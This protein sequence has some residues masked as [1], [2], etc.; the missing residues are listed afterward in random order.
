MLTL[1]QVLSTWEDVLA[2]LGRV[3]VSW[4]G[5]PLSDR[6][7]DTYTEAIVLCSLHLIDLSTRFGG[8]GS[9]REIVAWAKNLVTLD[10]YDVGAALSEV[11]VML[12][13]V[14]AP[15]TYKEFKRP[16]C[17]E[18]PFMGML[19]APIR[20]ALSAFLRAPNYRG[21]YVVYQSLS[22]LT[23]L[24]LLD[25]PI[26]LEDEYVE[27]ENSLRSGPY[28]GRMIAEM[29]AIM[30]E[31][32]K[33]FSIS[34]ENFHPVHGPGATAELS[35][36]ANPLSKYV[37]AS[38]HDPL[39][40]Y[41]FRHYAGVDV[42]SYLPFDVSAR[43]MSRQAKVVMVPKSIK[44]R[45]TISKESTLLQYLEQAIARAGVDYVHAHPELS[46]HIDL[47]DQAANA[48]LAID[49]SGDGR[50]STIDLSSAS[51][52]VTYTNVKA[53]FR[54]TPLYPYLVALRSR[55]AELP[56]GRVVELEKYAPMGSALCFLVE[57]LIFACAVEYTVRR[58]RRT[59]L[60][61][62]PRWRVY[63]DDIIVQEPL[64]E[65]TLL[66]LGGLG[67]RVNESKSFTYPGR[68]RESCGGE[69]Y[70]GYD[71]TPLKISRRFASVRGGFTSSHAAQFIGTVEM[72]NSCHRYGFQYTRAWLV[73]SC[74]NNRIAPPLFSETGR[75]SIYSP[76]P[77]NYRAKRRFSRTHVLEVEVCI[78]GL[79][80]RPKVRRFLL[81]EE[82]SVDP[83]LER[84]RYFEALRRL[85]L[86]KVDG[87]LL[88]EDVIEVPCSPVPLRLQKKWKNPVAP[89]Q[90]HSRNL[91]QSNH[92]GDV[93]HLLVGDIE[94]WSNQ[95][96]ELGLW[97]DSSLEQ[98]GFDPDSRPVSQAFYEG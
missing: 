6:D 94:D 8:I 55:T 98:V 76:R 13:H 71:V 85:S 17:R 95:G 14:H 83:T 54:G 66:T 32:M 42:Y 22:F 74:L 23:H 47:R 4:R 65:D 64:F 97:G 79:P 49:G 50:W 58:A 30:K 77:D 59:R 43:R 80:K 69:G 81:E 39:I 44:T 73:R 3:S 92:V 72:A 62:F 5:N 46:R 87:E 34:E 52:T 25:I 82:N 48:V 45:R 84:A 90:V 33:D 12:R 29:N 70:D 75:G 2:Q 88:P 7:R 57:S 96:P 89:L 10:V 26:D 56:S 18:Y 61:S 63:G 38:C 37:V 16:L 1:N 60:G 53:V 67:F 11:V 24:T 15:T 28:N 93:S 51:D 21:F 36:R 35:A 19:L 91:Y 20:G 78:G 40:E 9:S 86:R 27:L 41:V 68:F 31:W